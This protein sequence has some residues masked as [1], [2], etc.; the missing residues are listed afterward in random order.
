MPKVSSPP[1]TAEDQQKLIDGIVR[2]QNLVTLEP[3]LGSKQVDMSAQLWKMSGTTKGVA[4]D[5]IVLPRLCGRFVD[6]CSGLKKKQ[7]SFLKEMAAQSLFEFV[8]K[9]LPTHG[10]ANWQEIAEAATA[11]NDGS[12]LTPVVCY[13]TFL[14]GSGTTTMGDHESYKRVGKE[15]PPRAPRVYPEGPPSDMI[16]GNSVSEDS[17][18]LWV[19]R[20]DQSPEQKA[21]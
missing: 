19:L 16:P 21:H 8:R 20:L 13:F 1:W 17:K 3:I 15:Q 5:E 7:K 11:K 18:F 12:T 2:G 10:D 6:A 9:L 14:C 4:A